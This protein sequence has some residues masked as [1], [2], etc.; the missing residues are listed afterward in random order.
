MAHF[1]MILVITLKYLSLKTHQNE[2]SIVH[3][4]RYPGNR[5]D[6]WVFLRSR[7]RIDPYFISYSHYSR[8]FR[9]YPQGIAITCSCN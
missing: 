2:R 3:Y 1:G 5:M 6:I 8:A 7:W 4:R 9:N